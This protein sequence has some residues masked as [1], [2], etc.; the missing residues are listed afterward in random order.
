MTPE[1]Q[2][3]PSDDS[4]DSKEEATTNQSTSQSPTSESDSQNQ[5]NRHSSL[6]FLW[7]ILG[8]IALSSTA[9]F[10]KLSIREISAEATVFNR[11]WIATLAFTGLNWL[12]R[13]Q[14]PSA[15]SESKTEGGY[16]TQNSG[17][18]DH[19]SAAVTGQPQKLPWATINLLL[20]L[21]FV[22]LVGRYLWTWSLTSTT[23][24]NGAMLANMPPLFTALGGWLF[25]GQRFDRRF[26][27]GLAIAVIGAIT[28]AIGDWIQPKE[29]LFGTSALL[30]DGAALLSSVFY[31]ASF[32]LVEKL[33]Q[34]LSTSRILVWRCAIGLLLATPIVW[35]IDSTI[36]PISTMGWIAVIGLALISEVT[37]HGLIVY[38]LKHFSSTFVT[39]VLLLEPAPVAAIAW[40]WFGEFLDPLNILGFFLITIGIYLAKTGTGATGSN[41]NSPNLILNPSNTSTS[42]DLA[43]GTPEI[44]G[45]S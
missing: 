43:L 9:I 10:I 3:S 4:D 13:E 11:L 6:A 7:L 28:L 37:G 30:G 29:A 17:A 12:Q 35:A 14:P 44:S 33:R 27:S 16:T 19:S 25:L 39:I 42:Q 31:A 34:R 36:F 40:L 1:A 26:L 2:A 20:A 8:L 45:E 22:H 24:A 5:N 15:V 23:A 18:A 32:L 21:G 41:N 38:S